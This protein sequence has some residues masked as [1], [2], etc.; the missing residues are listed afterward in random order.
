[1]LGSAAYEAL[2]EQELLDNAKL[3]VI[4]RRN[5][6]VHHY[7]LTHM[8]QG[9]DEPFI[10]F[11]SHLQPAARIGKFKKKGKCNILNCPG[12]IEVDYT[13]EMVQD[14]L[15]RGLADEEIKGLYCDRGGLYTWKI[16]KIF[17]SRGTG[18]Q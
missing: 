11:E 10:N 9:H 17:G 13:E 7:K 15:I 5:K 4:K 8:Q 1:M 16:I 2:S 12:E 18:S 6:Y 14:N 3:F